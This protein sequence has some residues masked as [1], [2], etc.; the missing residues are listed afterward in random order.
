LRC[1]LTHNS[2]M[3]TRIRASEPVPSKYMVSIKASLEIR[4]TMQYA[5]TPK[6]SAKY[7]SLIH[8]LITLVAVK[9]PLL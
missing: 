8:S 2:H 6:P 7:G 4:R 1:F 9:P 3:E 5:A